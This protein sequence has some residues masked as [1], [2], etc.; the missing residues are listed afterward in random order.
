MLVHEGII[1]QVACGELVGRSGRVLN[2]ELRMVPTDDVGQWVQGE[3]V[4]S[5]GYDDADMGLACEVEDMDRVD[6]R[7]AEV[8]D[9]RGPQSAFDES[10]VSVQR[11]RPRLEEM[12]DGLS[13]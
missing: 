4:D 8:A 9:R 10:I 12:P 7:V 1:L 5:G 3:D 13:P 11:V 2:V 6:I